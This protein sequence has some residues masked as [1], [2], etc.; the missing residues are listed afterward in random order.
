MPLN[1]NKSKYAKLQ[2]FWARHLE[3]KLC[4]QSAPEN[5][6]KC[7]PWL[8]ARATAGRSY[9]AD[10]PIL[11]GIVVRRTNITTLVRRARP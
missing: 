7:R 9:S 3:S 5:K 10:E 1:N 2:Q 6:A 11:Y 4:P 8:P